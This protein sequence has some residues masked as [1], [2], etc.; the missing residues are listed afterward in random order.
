MEDIGK[1]TLKQMEKKSKL[2]NLM[3]DQYIKE[4]NLQVRVNL[5]VREDVYR[6]SELGH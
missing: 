4:I 3:V 6:D 1:M 2:I 5:S